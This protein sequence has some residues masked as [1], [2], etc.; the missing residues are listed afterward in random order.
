MTVKF[1][2]FYIQLLVVVSF[3]RTIQTTLLSLGDL[4]EYFDMTKVGG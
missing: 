4:S 3:V 1:L 2:K